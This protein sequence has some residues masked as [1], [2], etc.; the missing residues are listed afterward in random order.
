MVTEKST[1]ST[2]G[3]WLSILIGVLVAISSLSGIFNPATY[4]K[5]TANWAMQAVG[6]DIGN[7]LAV[8]TLLIST[9]MLQK[10]SLQAYFIWLGTLFYFIYAYLIYAFF[11]HFNYLFLVYV[12]ILGLSSYT[13]LGGLVG[14]GIRS[15]LQPLS[16]RKIKSASV[17]LIIIG[18]LFGFLWLSELIPALLSGQVPKS[19]MTAGLWVNPIHV[20]DLALV[21][22]GMILTGIFLWR[23]K[24]MGYLFAVPWLTFSVLMGSSIVATMIMELMNGNREATI[25]LIMVG[26]IV[27]AS[28]LVLYHYLANVKRQQSP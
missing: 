15:I 25:P 23:K 28:L 27:L 10:R 12:A 4:A 6:Q 11:I 8:P 14:Q 20:I 13:L 18:V 16:N 5:E 22:P 1:I 9:Y 21:L 26:I 3:V 24:L 2:I 7:L 17:L 19:T